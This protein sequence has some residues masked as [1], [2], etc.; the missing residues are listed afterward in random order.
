MPKSDDHEDLMRGW[1]NRL[2]LWWVRARIRAALRSCNE[3]AL[4]NV[5]G[6]L[7]EGMPKDGLASLDREV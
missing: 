3:Q 7:D 4:A 1:W 5:L 6:W 2:R